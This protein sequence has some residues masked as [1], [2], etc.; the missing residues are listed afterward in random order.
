MYELQDKLDNPDL[1]VIAGSRL[2]GTNTPESD[3]DFR[4]FVTPPF[5]YLVGLNNFKH[6]I[7]REPDT[8][9][10]SITRFFQLLIT[11][12]PTTYEA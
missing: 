3:T 4:G 1:L 7:I 12:D 10:Y 9:I 5:E 11:G 6:Q 2:Y 8:V